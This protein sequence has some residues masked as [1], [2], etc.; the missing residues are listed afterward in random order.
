MLAIVASWKRNWTCCAPAGAGVAINIIQV[1]HIPMI[2]RT[3]VLP[4]QRPGQHVI[5]ERRAK[6]CNRFAFI[7]GASI[8]FARELR[9]ISAWVRAIPA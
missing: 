3:G 5:T 2:H 4:T 7:F 8:A 1:T 6:K 9:N